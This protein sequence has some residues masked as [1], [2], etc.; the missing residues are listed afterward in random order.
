VKPRP[1]GSGSGGTKDT[2]IPIKTR[3]LFRGKITLALVDNNDVSSKGGA[4]KKFLGKKEHKEGGDLV[5]RT[6]GKKDQ[7][8][9]GQIWGKNFKKPPSVKITRDHRVVGK[10]LP[11]NKLHIAPHSRAKETM[12]RGAD[13][14]EVQRERA[15]P[16]VINFPSWKKKVGNLPRASWGYECRG[17]QARRWEDGNRA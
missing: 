11:P 2:K 14:G 3:R 5:C 12:K 4:E 1:A 15:W 6:E 13:D 7:K 17:A 10:D 9:G 16:H 8:K